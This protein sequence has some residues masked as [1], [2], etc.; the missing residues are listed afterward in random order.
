[1]TEVRELATG[2]QFPEG[3]VAM[4]D[5]SVLVVEIK[6]GT[7]TRV[8][9]AGDVDV[10]ADLG[11][12]PNGAA[13]GPDG[14]VYVCNDG[15]FLWSERAGINIPMDLATGS[16]QPPVVRC[17][18]VMIS[19]DSNSKA[20]V[21]AADVDGGSYD[22]AEEV[23]D[24]CRDLIRMDTTN[25]GD[26]TIRSGLP[27]VHSLVSANFSGGGMS[28]MDTRCSMPDEKAGFLWSA[29]ALGDFGV[30]GELFL[31]ARS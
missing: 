18:D 28:V 27:C 6:R 10:V 3:P 9:A 5:G 22:P 21:T 15:G 23:V 20:T 1:M 17:H 30:R 25:F 26:D 11:G 4:A 13:I 24:I 12:G 16:N 8:G 14:A 19:A 31:S 7:L 2:L 29:P